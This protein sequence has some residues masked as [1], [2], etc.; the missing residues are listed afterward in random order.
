MAFTLI[1]NT[2][3]ASAAGADT[4]T[5][6]IDTT[7]ANLIV[8]N[9]AWL[10]G[11]GRTMS[12][13]DS[14][15]NTWTAMPIQQQGGGL[16]Q[17]SFYCYAPTVGSGHTFTASK[18]GSN[19]FSSVYVQA[20]S[21]AGTSPFDQSNG[22]ILTAV[23]TAEAGS[24][25]PTQSNEL[26]VA[27]LEENEAT[28]FAVSIGSSYTIS[29]QITAVGG[30][31]IGGAFAYLLQGSAAATNPSWSWNTGTHDANLS[32]A[33]FKGIPASGPTNVK[34]KDG[35]TQSTGI[36]TYMGLALASVKSVEGVT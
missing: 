29:D 7:G 14:K 18:G 35:V 5:N 13:S 2:A 28:A 23:T 21:G 22:A 17:D 27:Y 25:T 19:I 36:K 33:S 10:N 32:I 8:I 12:F 3:K 9:V 30:G 34:T 26:I 4:T 16:A 31:T 6:A 20:W 11:G 15:S 1:A 24:I